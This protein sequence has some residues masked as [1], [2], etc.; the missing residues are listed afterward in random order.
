[1]KKRFI[2]CWISVLLSTSY[3]EKAGNLSPLH[4]AVY[5]DPSPVVLEW[6]APSNPP[7]QIIRY[8]VYF[9]TDPAIVGNFSSSAACIGSVFDLDCLEWNVGNL[10]YHTAY[11]WRIDTVCNGGIIEYGTVWNF[12][13]EYIDIPG[14]VI[15][16]SPNPAATYFGSPS[17]AKLPNETYVASHDIFGS[18]K[19]ITDIFESKNKGR[20]WKKISRITGQ[21]WSTIFYHNGALYIMGTSAEYGK[22]FIRKSTDGGYSWTNPTN[23]TNGILINDSP[24]HTSS[25]PVVVHNGRI[26]RAMEDA[27]DPGGWG[28]H[29]RAFMMSA[30][31][32][33]D[34]LNA[35]SWLLTNRLSH[36][37]TNWI[38]TGWLEGNAVVDLQGRMVNILRV[39]YPET[40]A[41]VRISADGTTASFD[42][43]HD[44]IHFYGGA[45]KFTIRYDSESGRYWSLV[46]K[47][48]D[49]TAFRN[50]VALVSSADLRNWIVEDIILEHPEAN[51]HAWQYIDWL[52]EDNDLIFVSR[53]AYDTGLGGGAHNAHDANFM[54]FH[55]IINFRGPRV[56]SF[57]LYP[58][59]QE[60]TL[61]QTA[62]FTAVAHKDIS[63]FQWFKEEIGG[64]IEL[65]HG[66]D[67]RIIIVSD[68]Q[69]TTLT[70]SN[71]QSTDLGNY[72]CIA[73]NLAGSAVSQKAKLTV[74]ERKL[75]GRWKLDETT[76]SW[77][78]SV[79]A[80][81]RDSVTETEGVLYGYNASDA[82]FI[83]ANVI[84]RP[85]PT[86]KLT[87]K[88]YD[89]AVD[90]G[91][92]G[93][94]TLRTDVVPE[95]GD[96]TIL[97]WMKTSNKHT[98][99]GHLFSNNNGQPNRCN[100]Y[101]TNGALGWFHNGGLTLSEANS[102]IFDGNWHEVGVARS[103]S[104]WYLLRDGNSVASGIAS[105]AV[106]QAEW[107]IGRMR[108]YDGDYEGQIG[109]VKVYNFCILDKWDL[110]KDGIVNL[111]D[112]CILSQNWLSI[113]CEAC[114]GADPSLDG[115][116]LMD[117]LIFITRQ[118]LQ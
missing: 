62:T 23:Q 61:G 8:D 81:V 90:S 101:L 69:Q 11:Y 50:R 105:G 37:R 93:V 45:A 26:W 32:G 39:D 113:E 7:A 56:P 46:N 21:W 27:K 54:T 9:G 52:I 66:G 107:M 33:S 3:A 92:S 106:S 73:T 19:N 25:V 20:T 117:D 103:G 70:I 86:G 16:A 97:V 65:L 57:D 104:N 28:D 14:V 94:N 5:I 15:D 108:K 53:T 12:T 79:Y 80:G 118:W 75:L 89:F 10:N 47:Q 36:D 40:A 84:N 114:K 112:F 111:S 77:N 18:S 1:M 22:C 88:A 91:I 13:T 82:A 34:L 59:D 2:G 51:Y 24:Y 116:V 60:I 98:A 35:D 55:R 29:F 115:S 42:P 63:D 49:P 99:Q 72:Y 43:V 17:I 76:L 110:N 41:I 68:S 4:E 30:D 102:P 83:N 95:T 87:D 31:A 6:V 96:F 38:G 44:F 64:D 109:E 85:G 67:G 58:Q 78:G 48:A 100:L 71:I 74:Y